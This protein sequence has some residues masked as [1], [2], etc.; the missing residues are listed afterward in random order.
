MMEK[1]G[2]QEVQFFA[3]ILGFLPHIIQ[4]GAP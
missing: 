2:G 4:R 3:L 1:S